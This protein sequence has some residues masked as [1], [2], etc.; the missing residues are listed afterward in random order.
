MN[1]PQLNGYVTASAG[2][3]TDEQI[4]AKRIYDSKRILTDVQLKAKQLRDSKRIRTN[5]IQTNRA[6]S[7]AQKAARAEQRRAKKKQKS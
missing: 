4:T 1:R 3:R 7:P 2:V 5:R 6:Y